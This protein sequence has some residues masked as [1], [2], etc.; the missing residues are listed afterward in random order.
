MRHLTTLLYIDAVARAGSIRK[1]AD[2]LSITSTALNRRLLA[3]EEDLGVPIFERL[4]RGVR[5]NAA[6]ELLIQHI[7]HQISDMARVRSQI[8]DLSGERRGHVSIACSQAVLVYLPGQIA[9]YRA[10]HPGVTFGVFRRDRAAA[11]QALVDHTADLALVFEPIRLAEFQTIL[12]VRQQVH[13]MLSR[14][15]PLARRESLRLRECL[16]YPI[17]LPTQGY[18]VRHLLEIALVDSPIRLT[19]A[20]ESDSFEFLRYQVITEGI[21]SFQIPIGLAQ[22]SLPPGMVTVPI[23]E[24][25]VPT[26]LIYVGQLRGRTLPVAAARFADQL[27][28][29]LVEQYE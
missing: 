22:D 15:H 1:A 28:K 2:S 8:A 16:E 13:A 6:G 21:V 27:T 5:L 3:I 12:T 18:G 17:A 7:R 23:D 9:R 26:G 11:E 24:R 29:D 19:P 14:D 20:I 10:E 25:D 4:P